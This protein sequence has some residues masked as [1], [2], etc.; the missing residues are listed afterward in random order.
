MLARPRAACLPNA[1]TQ[2]AYPTCL[3]L[4]LRRRFDIGAICHLLPWPVARGEARALP[5]PTMLTGVRSGFD[6]RAR[7]PPASK[8]LVSCSCE[9]NQGKLAESELTINCLL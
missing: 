6:A 4:T 5:T 3:E 1:L 2:H 8:P 7:G 9:Q